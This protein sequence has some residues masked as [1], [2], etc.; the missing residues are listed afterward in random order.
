ML[1]RIRRRLGLYK[2]A[3]RPASVAPAQS[4]SKKKGTTFVSFQRPLEQL[5]RLLEPR[6]VLEFGPGNSTRLFLE[7]TKAR[8]V[9]VESDPGWHERYREEFDPERVD[10]I[11]LESGAPPAGELGT[12]FD[13]VFVDGGDR[14]ELLRFAR[15]VL[16][17]RGIVYLHDAHREEYE[18]GFGGYPFVYF[19]E[20][21]SALFC[22]DG[23]T[24]RS[25]RQA[26]P[27]DDSCACKYCSTPERRAYFEKFRARGAVAQ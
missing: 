16:G 18:E 7:H 3:P 6:R 21:H 22:A 14:V 5:C 11:L 12:D 8:I 4:R 27:L 15:S 25:V 17:E 9:S 1:D 26:V 23:A 20:R 24:F 2:E 13:L 10:C 19:P